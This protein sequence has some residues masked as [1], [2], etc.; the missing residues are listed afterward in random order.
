M[1]EY[2]AGAPACPI[3]GNEIVASEGDDEPYYWRCVED[4]C[5]RRSIGQPPLSIQ[6]GMILCKCGAAVEYGEWGGKPCWRCTKDRKHRLPLAKTHL[7]LPKMRALIPKR[8]V[9]RWEKRFGKTRGDGS[10]TQGRTQRSL[11]DVAEDMP[12]GS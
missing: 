4:K 12:E 8:I 5:Y 10:A 7:L 11:F 6:D 9:R 3:C 2:E 1:S